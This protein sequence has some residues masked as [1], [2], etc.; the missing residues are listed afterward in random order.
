M[1]DETMLNYNED[2]F[3]YVN[4]KPRVFKMGIM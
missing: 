2:D 1:V 3:N 4:S